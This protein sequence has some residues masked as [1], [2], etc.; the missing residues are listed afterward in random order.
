MRTMEARRLSAACK[1]FTYRC[2]NDISKSDYC[3]QQ[4]HIFVYSLSTALSEVSAH[5]VWKGKEDK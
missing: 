3:R 1:G 5:V 4:R 2:G